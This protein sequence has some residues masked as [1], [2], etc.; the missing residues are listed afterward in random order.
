MANIYSSISI[1]PY[2]SAAADPQVS[3]TAQVNGVSVAISVWKSV[4]L[5]NLG[6]AIA[7]SNWIQPL[8]LAAY[9][10]TLTSTSTP[11]I[12]SFTV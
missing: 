6:T 8:L 7:F 9:N 5:A 4:L 2:P 10:N 1:Q 12:T 11:P 3:I